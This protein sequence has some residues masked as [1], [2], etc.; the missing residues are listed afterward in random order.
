MRSKIAYT[1][2]PSRT[3]N[4]PTLI[5][6][7][8]HH[9][10]WKQF[11]DCFVCQYD[12]SYFRHGVLLDYPRRFVDVANNLQMLISRFVNDPFAPFTLIKWPE[13]KG[14]LF[15]TNF[16]NH[17]WLKWL[18]F[19]SYNISLVDLFTVSILQSCIF[20]QFDITCI[21]SFVKSFLL[22]ITNIHIS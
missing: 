5:F 3:S 20:S 1:I 10:S 17:Y 16:T 11:V 13:V 2:A 4:V 9:L 18:R 19:M 22:R 7:I 21:P 14:C 8:T 12:M 6:S 15:P